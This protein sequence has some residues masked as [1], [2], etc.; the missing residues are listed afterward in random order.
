MKKKPPK[1]V[2]LTGGYAGC[3]R[4]KGKV[5]YRDN[6]YW[7]TAFTVKDDKVYVRS[8]YEATK[9]LDGLE[10]VPVTY[11]EWYKDNGEDRFDDP[12][13]KRVKP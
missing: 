1:F 5:Y 2:R 8:T 11:E 13:Y 6:G 7:E 12:D 9:H 3:L 4:L 10:L